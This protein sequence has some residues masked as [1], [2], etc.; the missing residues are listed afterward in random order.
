MKIAPFAL[1]GVL[2][3]FGCKGSSPDLSGRWNLV[4]GATNMQ[5]EFGSNGQYTGTLIGAG[6]SG[7]ASGSYS[8]K[9]DVLEMQPP[10]VTGP[11]GSASPTGGTMRVKLV[12][13]GPN[14]YLLDAGDQKFHMTKISP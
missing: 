7:Q 14:A 4:M 10:T 3:L 11:G 2:L 12:P 9:G 5:V 8:L 6:G 13:Q 1:F